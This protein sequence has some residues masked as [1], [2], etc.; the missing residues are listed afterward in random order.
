MA[1]VQALGQAHHLRL[2][3]QARDPV[4]EQRRV[5][6]QARAQEG[7]SGLDSVLELVLD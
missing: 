6:V 5:Q 4:L 2:V 3:V 1:R 7:A